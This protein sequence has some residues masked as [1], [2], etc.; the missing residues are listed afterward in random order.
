VVAAERN[1]ARLGRAGE[2]A[3]LVVLVVKGYRVRHRNWRGPVGELDLVVE[4]GTTI[5]FVEVKTR[6]S[7]LFGGAAA[8]LGRSKQ[9]A[10]A[11]TA[12]AY[13]SRYGLWDRPCRFDLV[14]IERSKSPPWWRL[15]HLTGAFAPDLGRI[16][17]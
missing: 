11:R 1:A 2:L 5:V 9:A 10:V 7:G 6:S 4:R 13:L 14:A 8:A 17:A 12:A 15:R 3:A 16:P